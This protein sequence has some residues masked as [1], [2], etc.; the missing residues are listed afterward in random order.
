MQSIQP[1]PQNLPVQSF[2][3]VALYLTRARRC[4]QNGQRQLAWYCRGRGGVTSFSISVSFLPSF[5]HLL[6]R[7][8]RV[9]PDVL[10][11]LYF[12]FVI[13]FSFFFDQTK[14]EQPFRSTPFANKTCTQNKKRSN[15]KKEDLSSMPPKHDSSV[16]SLC[17][18]SYPIRVHAHEYSS[19]SFP[20]LGLHFPLSLALSIS[21]SLFLS[22][23]EFEPLVS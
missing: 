13:V 16:F 21:L 15:R 11:V 23:S 22:F 10:H 2:F 7:I 5:L 6:Q 18:L 3:Y 14:T 9:Q 4:Q 1:C 19:I 20:F 8:S 12:L 17:R